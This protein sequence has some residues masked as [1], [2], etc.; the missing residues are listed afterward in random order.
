MLVYQNS[1]YN[2]QSPTAKT[3]VPKI[4][5]YMLTDWQSEAIFQ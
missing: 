1:D 5:F 4:H 2:L 3:G